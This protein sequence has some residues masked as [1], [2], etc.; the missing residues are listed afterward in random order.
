M[1]KLP[2][3]IVGDSM[4]AHQQ[5]TSGHFIELWLENCFGQTLTNA[6]EL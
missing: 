4:D 6:M 5:K 1:R 2:H 3:A